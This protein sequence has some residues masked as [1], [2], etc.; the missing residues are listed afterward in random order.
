MS[1]DKQRGFSLIEL[2]IFIVVM[3]ILMTGMLVG[4]NRSLSLTVLPN[5]LA[6]A[7]FLANARMEVILLQRSV[8]G[9]GK[10]LDPCSGG[11]PPAICTPLT[12]FATTYGFTVISNF[13]TTGANTTIDVSVTGTASARTTTVVSNF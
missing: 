6:Q 5:Q 3:S 1:V 2:V 9:W 13:S 12:S 4:V 8:Q 11:S 10:T 7:M